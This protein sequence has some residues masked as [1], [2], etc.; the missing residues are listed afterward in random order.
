MADTI[1]VIDINNTASNTETIKL[2]GSRPDT[3][4]S[5]NFGPGIEML[6]NEKKK[7]GSS[8]PK[9]DINISDLDKLESELNDLSAPKISKSDATQSAFSSTFSTKPI[10]LSGDTNNSGPQKSSSPSDVGPT[11]TLNTTPLTGAPSAGIKAN[12]KDTKGTWDGYKKFNDIPVNPT[13][14]VAKADV[15]MSKEELLRKKFEYIRK[16]EI[17]EKKGAKVSKKYTM[18]SSLAEMQGEYEMIISEKE[19]SNSVKF[20]GKM[21]MACVTGLEFLNNR[22]DPFDFNLDGWAESVQE[23]IDDYDEIFG[24]LH[25]KYKSKA[26]MAPELKLLFQLAG[27]GIMVHMTNTMF[28]SSMPGMDD[29][30]RQNPDL[31][32]QFTSAAVN[33]MGQ[34]NPGFGNFMSSVMGGGQGGASTMPPMA[35]PPGP[36]QPSY[37]RPEIIPPGPSNRPDIGMSRGQPKFNDAA[38]MENSYGSAVSSQRIKQ[39]THQSSTKR[40]DMKGPRDIGDLLSGL[41]TKKIDFKGNESLPR[42]PSKTKVSDGSSTISID[43]LNL[44]SKDADNVP[45]KSKRK[46]KSER[47]TVSI[48]L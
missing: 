14:Q 1:Q 35:S 43:E 12:D 47:N 11:I 16:L 45:R 19:K 15:P 42:A 2:S 37:D 27:S 18:E 7:G 26:K 10:T 8:T 31:M 40:P 3:P 20:Q 44:I 6:M 21:L 46:P 39:P 17:L 4:K 23:N 25:E 34:Q 32:R 5:V 36:Q 9:S 24:E 28:K 13:A 33:T 29:I 41:K 38:N 30:M 22:F 48:S